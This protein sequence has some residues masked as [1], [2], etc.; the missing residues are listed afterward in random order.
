MPY[1]IYFCVVPEGI[2]QNFNVT[3]I[4]YTTVYISWERPIFT[5]ENGI[6]VMYII[7]YN[8]SREEKQTVSDTHFAF[9]CVLLIISY[10]GVAKL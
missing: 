10:L 1:N 4:N 6:I 9:L 5:E 2:P 3:P 8:G 7:T